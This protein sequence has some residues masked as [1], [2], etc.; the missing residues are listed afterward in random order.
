MKRETV[1]SSNHQKTKKNLVF[2]GMSGGVD[3]S[4]SAALLLE[5]G[6]DVVGVFIKVWQPDFFEC[7]WREDRL[8]AMRVC[9]KLGIPFKT[10]D[11]EKE[12]KQEVVDYMIAEYQIGRVPNPDV[13]CNR[14]IKFGGFYDWAIENCADFVATGHYARLEKDADGVAHL[15]AGSDHNKD[16]T[17]FLWAVDQVKWQKVI[18]PV[19]DIEKP[20][21]RKLAK[22][23][24]LP[25]AEKKDSQG[26]CFIGKIN[27]RDFLKNFIETKEGSVLND[28][29]EVIGTHD[30]ACLY[31]LGQRHGF[32]LSAKGVNTEKMYVSAKDFQK[33]T[34][35]ISN[36][37]TAESVVAPSLKVSLKDINQI[38]NWKTDKNYLARVRYRQPLQKCRLE[39]NSTAWTVVFVEPQTA[40]SGQS[41]VIYDGEECL[42][43]GIIA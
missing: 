26:V 19:G 20:Q 38:Q 6:Y 12:Y 11:L 21:V 9:A 29:G 35:T 18:F 31:T 30:G 3:S 41:I 10:L 23:F 27:I 37:E 7:T 15:F 1:K 33:N 17:Y 36:K 22:K 25:N 13:M 28:V 5:Q 16:Q 39:N 4:V 32:S 40:D 24:N 34:I 14:F 43:G 2:V 8:D 42:G